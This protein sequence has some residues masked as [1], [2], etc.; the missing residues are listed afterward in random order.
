MIHITFE[1]PD[2]GPGGD[3]ITEDE[4]RTWGNTILKPMASFTGIEVKI[5]EVATVTQDG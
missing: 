4:V 3:E 5:V 2:A 1:F